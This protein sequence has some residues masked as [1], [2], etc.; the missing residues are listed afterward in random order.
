MNVLTQRRGARGRTAL[1]LSLSAG[2]F[3]A[4]GTAQ[5]TAQTPSSPEGQVFSMTND[6]LGNAVTRFQ[7]RAD[8]QL[9]NPRTVRTGGLGTGTPE[10]SANGLILADTTG[11][12]SPTDTGGTPRFL[13][14]ANGGSNTITVF[15]NDP[16]GLK[17]VDRE[18]SI[19]NRPIS[20]TV[21]RGV[22]YVLNGGGPMCTG[23]LGGPSITGF[24]FDTS[25]NLTPIPDSTRRVS[26]GIL[27]GCTQ[28]AFDKTGDVLLVEEQQADIISTYT[29][30]ANGTVSGPTARKTTGNGPFGL[31]FT[32]TNQLLTT[33]NASAIPL[34][35]GLAAYAIDTSTGELRPL[36]PSVGNGQSDT[37]WVAL[38]DD[39]R[40]AYTSSFGGLG[41]IS[42]YRV[43]PDGSLKLLKSLA[44]TVGTGSSDV[45][46][47]ADSRFLEVKNTILGTV[48]TYRIESDGGLT[49]VDTDRDAS[50]LLSSI[51]I[52]AS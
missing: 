44:A 50:L 27:S 41:A 32:R 30:N 19:G 11:E 35:G 52:A 40:F 26:G 10:D 36:G 17:V 34:L 14:A 13:L 47:S 22:A 33:E 3:A 6:A 7:R 31:N 48:T 15:R 46:L 39:G 16:S 5:A 12:A 20:I 28:V 18:P 24:T 49:K 38:T 21:S 4:G 1:I 45:A 42:S 8:G 51:G 9:I 25:G 29:R 43:S 2:V 23:L 37:C